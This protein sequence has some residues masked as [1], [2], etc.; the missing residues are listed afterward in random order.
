L[1][2][3]SYTES[4][5]G[6]LYTYLMNLLAIETSCDE[7][8]VA[9]LQDGKKVLS[10]KTFSQI[11]DHARFGGVVPEVASRAHEQWLTPLIQECLKEAQINLQNLAA[12]AVTHGPGLLGSLMIGQMA[13]KSLSFA[14]NIPL[15]AVNHLE[16]HIAANFMEAEPVTPAMILIVSGGHTHLYLMNT[17]LR[18]QLIGKTLDDAA[19]EAF[20]KTARLLNLPMPGGPAIQNLAKQGNPKNI[21]LPATNI[22][23]FNFSY[24]GLKTAVAVALKKKP[25]LNTADL[26]AAFQNRAIK[27]LVEKTIAAA[28]QHQARAIYVAGGVSANQML[29]EQL[30]QT[31]AQNN[32]PVHFPPLEF[33]TDNAVMIARAGFRLW[34]QKQF[35]DLALKANPALKLG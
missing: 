6:W 2:E 27:P 24:S 10:V 34:Q 4:I 19:G 21:P 31:G 11:F 30:I 8:S 16:G 25:T 18:Y 5:L 32:L 3:Y 33:C 29:R 7:S 14:L 1:R 9:V 35:S 15:I 13:A 20:D 12:I 17:Q 22:G 23:D 28:L 26:A